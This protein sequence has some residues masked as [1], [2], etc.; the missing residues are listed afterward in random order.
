MELEAGT[1]GVPMTYM[2][3]G[4]QYVIVP[5]GGFEV[6]GQFVALSLP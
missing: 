2:H 3:D 4:T 6:A 1:T 5:I